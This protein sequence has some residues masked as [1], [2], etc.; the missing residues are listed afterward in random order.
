MSTNPYIPQP[1]DQL[2]R[3]DLTLT[4]ERVFP[5][6]VAFSFSNGTGPFTISRDEFD[7]KARKSFSQGAVLIRGGVTYTPGQAT[8]PTPEPEPEPVQSETPTPEIPESLT[9]SS[10]SHAR[11]SPSDSKRWTNCTASIA[12]QEANAHRV[13]DD[14]S[15]EA[16]E[17][18]EAHEWAAKLLLGQI[19]PID[20]P[21]AFRQPVCDYV[22]HCMSLV[23]GAPLTNLQT[24]VED[25]DMGFAAP[26]T[27]VL[28]EEQV[29][30][31]YQPE[32]KGTAD[33][34]GILSVEGQV[35]RCY[36]R[37]YKHGAGVLVETESNTQLAIYV[38]SAIKALEGAYVFSDDTI[39]DLAI[40]QPRHREAGDPKPWVLTLKELAAFC[41]D[42]EYKA[43]T[44][45][46]AAERV[47]ER[48]GS[49][50][51]DVG[52]DEI[53]E[54]APGAV[55]APGFGD[56]GACRWCKCKAFCSENHAASVEGLHLPSMSAEEMLTLMPEVDG[57]PEQAIALTS[58][59]LGSRG[60][61]VQDDYLVRLVKNAPNI[62]KMLDN[63][64][65]YL[66]SRLIAGEEIPGLKLVNGREGNRT[67]SSEEQA[68][69][70][71]K[72]Q[73]LKQDERYDYK[74]K[75]PA[76]IEKALK[77]KLKKVARTKSRFEELI[78][79]SPAKKKLAID[80]DPREAVSPLIEAMPIEVDSETVDIES[81][82]V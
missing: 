40:V 80:D 25:T 43:I 3:G 60:L 15:R 67:W 27:A 28:V 62:R 79:R 16:D 2:T 59:V 22:D 53:R 49:P 41:W 74:L 18:T 31:F 51:R 50:G 47:R 1:H 5:F 76:A 14:S 39:V 10:N 37:D 36:G 8:D 26:E 35:V 61:I 20:I 70:F 65:E 13:R 7:A 55:F 52:T 54:A 73:G 32:Q 42:I 66:E 29:P 6:E 64:E 21:D 75:S 33:F 30:L 77:D 11:L 72:N 63:V 46:E 45:R 57:T 24:C 48:I 69:V 58:E 17:G 56:S 23:P 71:L 34:I 9:G 4:V 78:V 44:A 68:D 82:E 38:F 12:F 19:K 81:F